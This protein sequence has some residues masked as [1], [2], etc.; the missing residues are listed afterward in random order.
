MG[1]VS[2]ARA[3]TQST[4]A[5][6]FNAVKASSKKSLC[7]DISDDMALK[8]ESFPTCG[9]SGDVIALVSI[10]LTEISFCFYDMAIKRLD[11]SV[12]QVRILGEKCFHGCL[13]LKEVL[14][15]EILEEIGESCFSVTSLERLDLSQTHMGRLGEGV[16]RHCGKLRKVMFPATVKEVGGGCFQGTSL[17]RLDLSGTGIRT[18]CGVMCYACAR[19]R[20]VVVPIM[21]EEVGVSCCLGTALERL[22]LS[23]T[24]VVRL[25]GWVC[26]ECKLREVFAAGNGAADRRRVFLWYVTG[27]A[28]FVWDGCREGRAGDVRGVRAVA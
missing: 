3:L 7:L 17:E 4:N 25:G 1:G 8:L 18:L 5:V 22:D 28:G 9:N 16:C 24:C 12:T 14:L 10:W 11:L 27:A 19:L 6:M 21:L 13:E 23:G 15:P 26:Y 2:S 20:E